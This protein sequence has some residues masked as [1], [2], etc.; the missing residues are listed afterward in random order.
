M[1]SSIPTSPH[2]HKIKEGRL[3]R[4]IKQIFRAGSTNTEII[5]ASIYLLKVNNRNTRTRFEI[6]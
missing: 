5:P 2:P 3:N 1:K 4:V 6:C